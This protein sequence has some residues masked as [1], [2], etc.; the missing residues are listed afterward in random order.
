MPHRHDSSSIKQAKSLL[1]PGPSL[2]NHTRPK[3]TCSSS[4][5]DYPLV[6][7]NQSSNKQINYKNVDMG[8][9]LKKM[10]SESIFGK[11]DIEDAAAY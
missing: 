11:Q 10:L 6:K 8:A 3:T 4:N 1:H 7:R 5:G 9:K 2:E